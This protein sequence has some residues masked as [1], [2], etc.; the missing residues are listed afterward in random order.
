V[1]NPTQ[2]YKFR[3]RNIDW[4]ITFFKTDFRET[5]KIYRNELVLIWGNMADVCDEDV[6]SLAAEQLLSAARSA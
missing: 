4:K 1:R 2:G 3:D 6:I 5:V